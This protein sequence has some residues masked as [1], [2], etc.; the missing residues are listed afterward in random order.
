MKGFIYRWGIRIKECGERIGHVKIRGVFIF[1]WIA[2]PIITI[3]LKI[4]GLA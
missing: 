1:G 4:K 2:G 3:G